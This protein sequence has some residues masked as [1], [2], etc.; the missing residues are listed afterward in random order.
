MGKINVLFSDASDSEIIGYFGSPQDPTVYPNFR[1]IDASD[2]RWKTYYDAQP[3]Y[4]QT[5]LPIPT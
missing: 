5:L 1:Q 2:A 4:T 3:Q